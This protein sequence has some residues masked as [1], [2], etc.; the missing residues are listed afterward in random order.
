MRCDDK[1]VRLAIGVSDS[2]KSH[3]IRSD[4]LEAGKRFP[5]VVVDKLGEWNAID[6]VP[7]NRVA[8]V[9][10]ID[11]VPKKQAAG[12]RIIVFRT[13][14][15]VEAARDACAWAC[16]HKGRAGVA[17]QEAHKCI[18]NAGSMEEPI[19]DAITAWRHNDVATW[20]DSQRLALIDPTVRAQAEEV[21]LF[22]MWEEIDIDRGSRMGR[23]RVA[24]QAALEACAERFVK[25]KETG[26]VQWVGWHVRLGPV[27]KPPYKLTRMLPDGGYEEIDAVTLSQP[28][29]S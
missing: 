13:K 2:G 28:E 16:T 11:D 15:V 21:R 14:H 25:W 12:A 5:I 19:E 23:D 7:Q 3:S 8:W 24:L 9:T 20:W 26:D 27:R 10:S 22:T 29:A 18:P 17:V 6:G 4:V 1:G